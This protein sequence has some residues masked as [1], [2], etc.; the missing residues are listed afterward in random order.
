MAVGKNKK[1][2]KKRKGGNRKVVDPFSKKEWYDVKAPSAFP[3]R[4]VGKTM[5]TKTQGTKVA[6]DG[7]MGRVFEA[8]LGDLKANAEDDAFRKLKLKVEEVQGTDCLTNFYAM[9]LTSDKLRSLV[10]KWHSLIE[11]HADVK[12]SDGFI[13]RMY[14]I[15][16]TKRRPNQ[17]K[18]TSYAQSA[19]V[20]AIRKK[21]VDIMTREASTVDLNDLVAKLIP[22]S[23]GKEVEKA[24]EGIYPLQNVLIRKVVT[25]RAPKTDLNKLLEIHGGATAVAASSQDLG[26]AVERK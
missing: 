5:V 21:M 16:F 1:L 8:S 19:Q 9:D 2:G 17:I 7:L 13:L 12:T 15:G 20:R 6:K 26:K 25:L 10:R 22:E 11:A 18:K 3:I 24:C 4:Q 23:I 14:C